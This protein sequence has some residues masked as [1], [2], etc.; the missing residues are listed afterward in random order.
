MEESKDLTMIANRQYGIRTPLPEDPVP[1]MAY[2]PY[3]QQ[4]KMYCPE[5]GMVNGTLFPVLNKPFLGY[6]EE[7]R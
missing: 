6:K 1:A 2:V 3:Q 7:R 5:Q 4:G